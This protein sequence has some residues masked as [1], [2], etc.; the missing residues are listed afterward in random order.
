LIPARIYSHIRGDV[1]LPSLTDAW[2]QSLDVL[3]RLTPLSSTA[4][5]CLATLELL[6]DEIVS[7]ESY[8]SGN[9]SRAEPASLDVVS[10][11]TMQ[12]EPNTNGRDQTNILPTPVSELNFPTISEQRYYP[13]QYEMQVGDTFGPFPE[14]QDFTWLESLPAD[15]F[16]GGYEDMP[17]LYQGL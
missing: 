8:G 4:T 15:L 16:A 2:K 1:P 13:Q 5:K 17:Q 6:N 12:Y 9:V 14:L 3:R 11:I 10:A 7:E